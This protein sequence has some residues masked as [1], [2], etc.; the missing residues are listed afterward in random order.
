[1]V[2][3]AVGVSIKEVG[4]RGSKE[5]IENVEKGDYVRIQMVPEALSRGVIERNIAI[6]NRDQWYRIET[7]YRESGA[8]G[9]WNDGQP[10]YSFTLQG[11]GIELPPAAILEVRDH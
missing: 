11:H 2:L 5:V 1:V 9:P 8:G 6:F 3:R 7:V 10:E 4:R